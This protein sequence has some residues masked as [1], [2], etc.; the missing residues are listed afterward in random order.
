MSILLDVL[1]ECKT[2]EEQDQVGIDGK[3]YIAKPYNIRQRNNIF[4]RL[5]NAVR[6]LLGKSYTYHYAQDSTKIKH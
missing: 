4:K 1:V 5:K 6:V 3:W 2:R